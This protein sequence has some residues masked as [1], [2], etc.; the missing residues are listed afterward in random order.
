MPRKSGGKSKHS[1][2]QAMTQSICTTPGTNRPTGK[3]AVKIEQV[4]RRNELEYCLVR[5]FFEQAF[6]RLGRPIVAAFKQCR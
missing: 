1:R 5:V 3:M 4:S 2:P 6:T